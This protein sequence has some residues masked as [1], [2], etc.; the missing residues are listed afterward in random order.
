MNLPYLLRLACASSAVFFLLN[1][2]LGLAVWLAAPFAIRAAER[3]AARGAARFLFALRL[4]PAGLSLLAV[5]CVCVPSYLWL[6]PV[7]V[8][9]RVGFLCLA[10]AL[11]GAGVWTASLVRVFRALA[12]SRAFL[13]HCRGFARE[14]LLPHDPAPVWLLEN[15]NPSVALA[16]IVRPRLL[17]GAS[18]LRALSPGE[19][20]AALRHE[21]AHQRSRDNLKRLWLLLSPDCLPG[22]RAFA[23]IDRAWARFAEWA[24]DDSST[25]GDARRALSLAAALVRVSRMSAA[26]PPPVLAT[27]LLGA[28]SDLAVRVDRLLSENSRRATRRAVPLALAAPALVGIVLGT[29]LDPAILQAAHRFME[30]LID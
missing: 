30:T 14:V 27:P 4:L 9:E 15:S 26:A 22:I 16:G 7:D 28:A 24:A 10:A 25:Q 20:T 23:N 13:R 3:M 6:E 5:V 2:L 12:R 18:V 8:P 17:V 19:L 29:M 11:A 1:A 21:R